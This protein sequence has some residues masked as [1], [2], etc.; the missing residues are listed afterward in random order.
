MVRR[1]GN[2]GLS[3]PASRPSPAPDQDQ[4]KHK[5]LPGEHN[6]KNAYIHGREI[7]KIRPCLRQAAIARYTDYRDKVATADHECGWMLGLF[8]G[9]RSTYA[10]ELTT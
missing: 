7:W 3:I 10:D 9:E 8:R 2:H 4:R 6:N 1:G 5:V